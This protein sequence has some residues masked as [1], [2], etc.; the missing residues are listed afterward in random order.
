MKLYR[1]IHIY[2]QLNLF[3]TSGIPKDLK[4]FVNDFLLLDEKDQEMYYYEI[5]AKVMRKKEF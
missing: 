1:Y 5:K 4:D 3:S 2:T